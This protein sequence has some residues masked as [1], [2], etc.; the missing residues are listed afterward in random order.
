MRICGIDSSEM[1]QVHIG[2]VSDVALMPFGRPRIER[3]FRDIN[4]KTD[5]T[6]RVLHLWQCFCAGTCRFRTS[7]TVKDWLT[8]LGQS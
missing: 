8:N 1:L 5:A 3:I 7:V 6:P 2:I 4:D